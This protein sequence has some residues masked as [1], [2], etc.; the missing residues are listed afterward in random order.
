M[1][2]RLSWRSTRNLGW[3]TLWEKLVATAPAY[4]LS[5]VAAC[6]GF[7]L[8]S[9]DRGLPLAPV[10]STSK[11]SSDTSCTLRLLRF[12]RNLAKDQAERAL[13]ARLRASG[14]AGPA[15]ST[16]FG[17]CSSPNTS[18]H[19]VSHIFGALSAI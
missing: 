19:V 9:A 16:I 15:S 7:F 17:E 18:D 1:I 8:S 12:P 4:R 6:S 2:A 14:V 3:S 10:L 11:T 13:F 5:T